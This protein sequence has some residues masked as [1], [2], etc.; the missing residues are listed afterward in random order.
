M[1]AQMQENKRKKVSCDQ[2]C[3]VK[4]RIR[5]AIRMAT[6]LRENKGVQAN[7]HAYNMA[8]NGI[9][10]GQSIEIIKTL[11]LEPGYSHLRPEQHFFSPLGQ[12][13]TMTIPARK[14]TE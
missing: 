12:T 9:V 13:N 7:E 10:E 14:I 5:D 6:A 11:G 2:E 1:T 3:W 4:E 8:L